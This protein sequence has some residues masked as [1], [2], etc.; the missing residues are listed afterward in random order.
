VPVSRIPDFLERGIAAVGARIP[1]V[2]PCIFGHVGDGNLHANFSQPVD[3]DTDA[4]VARWD[5]VNRIVH[6]IVV[7]LGGSISAEHG[8]G[9]LKRESL[10]HYK[11]ALD[12]TLMRRIKAAIDPQGIMNPGKV[13]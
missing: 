5:E 4:Y 8:I 11:P 12:L 9:Q 3:M 6:D 7:D 1:G 2:R 10:Q 13:I